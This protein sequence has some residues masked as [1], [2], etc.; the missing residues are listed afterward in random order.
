MTMIAKYVIPNG[1]TNFAIYLLGLKKKPECLI[2][3][4]QT[5][6]SKKI[7]TI[8]LISKY[9]Y[10]SAPDNHSDCGGSPSISPIRTIAK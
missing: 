7:I 6:N 8:W 10:G 9:L 5:L 1:S 3:S 4:K 2:K